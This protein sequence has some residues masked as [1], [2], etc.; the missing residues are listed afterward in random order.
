VDAF[1][2]IHQRITK[3]KKIVLFDPHRHK[4]NLNAFPQ[5]VFFIQAESV[6]ISEM[7]YLEDGSVTVYGIFTGDHYPQPVKKRLDDLDGELIL[8][9]ADY[10][11]RQQAS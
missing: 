1:T 6:A 5:Y 9:L 11:C 10:L 2:Y 3:A 7:Q 8:G 4:G